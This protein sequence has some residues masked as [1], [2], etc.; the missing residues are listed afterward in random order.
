M[1]C[2]QPKLRP[3]SCS[4][5]EGRTGHLCI[6]KYISTSVFVLLLQ[7]TKNIRILIASVLLL[8]KE[9]REH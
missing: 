5:H 4:A 6:I 9:I 8:M 1:I 3:Q 2:L 7:T